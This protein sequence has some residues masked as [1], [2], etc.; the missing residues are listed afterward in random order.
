MPG[1]LTRLER[2]LPA[3]R[4]RLLVAPEATDARVLARLERVVVPPT[5]DGHGPHALR[6]ETEAAATWR[7]PA[8]RDDPRVPDRWTFALSGP[9]DATLRI[10]DGMAADLWRDGAD[11]PVLRLIGPAPFRGRLEAGRYHLDATSLGRNDRLDY[12]VSLRT[13]ELQPGVPREVAVS[14]QVP[15]ALAEPGVVSLT[16]FGPLPVKAVLRDGGGTVLGRYGARGADWNIAVSRLLP[17][18]SYR[19]DLAPAVPP[20]LSDVPAANRRSDAT[21]REGDA[22][23]SADDPAAQTPDGMPGG[24]DSAGGAP[25]ADTPAADTPDNGGPKVELTLMLPV[26]RPPVPAP[27]ARRHPGRRRRASAGRAPTPPRHAGARD[28]PVRRRLDPGDRTAAR[29]RLGHRGPGGGH[30]PN[31]RRAGRCRPG[32]LARLGLGR[33]RQ[34]PAGPGRR[35]A[36]GSPSRGPRRIDGPAG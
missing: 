4:L 21:R 24:G 23:D 10:G 36:A 34:R 35:R 13:A 33:G 17:A 2:D 16:S 15:F 8:G 30:R 28:G 29:R 6:P 19:L 32:A 25:D 1:E 7:E 5:Y 9:A 22:G 14:A 26:A 3:G 12:T 27:P 20:A 18:G 11:R 31:R